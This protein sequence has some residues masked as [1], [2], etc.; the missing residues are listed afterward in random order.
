[1]KMQHHKSITL[2]NL[3]INEE[4]QIG[5]QFQPDKIIQALLKELP[6]IKW[7]EEFGMAYIPNAKGN[8]NLIFQ[9]FK[10]VAWVNGNYFLSNKFGSRTKEEMD[11]NWF[12]NRNTSPD[13]R[14]CPEEYLLKLELVRY[15]N[16]T[17]RTYVSCFEQFINAYKEIELIQIDEND[18]RSYLQK[19]IQ[20]G[21]SDSYV[22]QMI[23]S[24]KFYYETVKGMPNRFY[25]VERPQKKQTLP[26]V[27]SIEEVQSIIKNTN[28]IKHKCIVSLLYS[29]GL[30]RSELLNLTMEDIDGKRMVILIRNGKGGKD[31]LTVLSQKVL[32]DLRVYFKEYKP[33]KYLFEGEKGKQ[34]SATSVAAIIRKAAQKSKIRK[35]VSPHMLRHSFATHLLENGTDLRYIQTLLGHSSTKTTEIYTQVAIKNIQLVKSPI[36]LINLD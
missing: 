34:Y 13:F 21:K 8:L 23:N 14:A 3:L 35:S 27:I 26:K 16:N 29:A 36:D 31:R 4:K 15:S 9:K 30:R 2:K 6:G 22:N 17:V 28:N 5:I 10:G 32:D 18:I 25:L 24:I 20:A 19:L 33:E 12:R 7:S 1:M 11:V